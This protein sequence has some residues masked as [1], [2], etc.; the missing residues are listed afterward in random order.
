[1]RAIIKLFFERHKITV[2]CVAILLL[3]PYFMAFAFDFGV[4]GWAWSDN[5][6]WISF[7]GVDVNENGNF[8]GHAWSD[9]VGWI[10]FDPA[11]PYPDC[12]IDVCPHGSPNYSARI[13]LNGNLSGCSGENDICGWMRV[14]TGSDTGWD[15]WILAGPV[16]SGGNNYGLRVD[17]ETSPYNFMG[18]AWGSE[19]IGWISFN[20]ENNSECQQSDYEVTV[21]FNSAPEVLDAESVVK[22]CDHYI[23]PQVAT[24]VSVT[25]NWDYY[26]ADGDSQEKYEIHVSENSNFPSDDRF[27]KSVDISASSC[28]LNLD[29]DSFWKSELDFNTTY[30]WRVRVHDGNFWS[31]WYESQFTIERTHPSPFPIFSY[32]PVLISS[33]EIVTFFSEK[34][35]DELSELKVSQVYDGSD[36]IYSWTFEGGNPSSAT[37]TST[38]TTTF[39]DIGYRSVTLEVTDASG[40]SCIR[41][42]TMDIKLPIPEWKE[43]SPFGKVRIFLADTINK[44][45]LLVLNGKE[46][47]ANL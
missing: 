12:P 47:F 14:L 16:F 2:F 11:G 28:S 6:G 33:G 21:S 44:I 27:E 5:I 46:I 1:M 22:Y 10:D 8:F 15:G 45:R 43:M 42:E 30:Y 25:F 34:W 38:V 40:Y 26:D 4:D 23:I 41:N 19:I 31:E 20:C 39:E 32:S 17:G 36:P 3:S 18:Y 37:S 29:D 13:D 24:G 9:T 7:D 35:D